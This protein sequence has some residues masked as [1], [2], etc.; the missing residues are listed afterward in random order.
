MVME[1]VYVG[2][3]LMPRIMYDAVDAADVPASGFD[4]LAGYE[5]GLY[6]S[7][8][9][10]RA[11]FPHATVVTIDVLNQP[12]TAQVLD[13]EK[14]DATPD[15]APAWFDASI[16]AGVDRP[17]LY[18]SSSDFPAIVRAMGRRSYDA[19]VASYGVSHCPIMSDAAC[20]VVAWQKIDHGP[21]GENIDISEVYDD[22]WNP[23]GDEMTD[24]DLKKIRQIVVEEVA[25]ALT[26][27]HDPSY[28]SHYLDSLK[29]DQIVIQK[30]G[31]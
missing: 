30:L 22:S 18:F 16:R 14:G 23:T 15:E 7:A 6:P 9:G 26:G 31:A 27:S 3:C 17:T 4:L 19:W 11:R 5:N 21:H 25:A 1:R 12:G 10:L 29:A 24:E 8:S 13:I 20:R 2:Q 28:R